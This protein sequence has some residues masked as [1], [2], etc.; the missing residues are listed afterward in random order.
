[1]SA[2]VFLIPPRSQNRLLHSNIVSSALIWIVCD[3]F[4]D[5][6]RRAARFIWILFFVSLNYSGVIPSKPFQFLIDQ[7][8]CMRSVPCI[9]AHVD[10]TVQF[11]LRVN[12]VLSNC[13]CFFFALRISRSPNIS[14]LLANS[15]ECEKKRVTNTGNEQK[16]KATRNK[17]PYL[18]I[19]WC[20]FLR[21]EK[22]VQVLSS[23]KQNKTANTHSKLN[24]LTFDQNVRQLRHLCLYFFWCSEYVFNETQAKNEKI[25]GEKR[26][27]EKKTRSEKKRLVKIQHWYISWKPPK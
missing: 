9:F 10:S 16:K 4:V 8:V 15:Q 19:H 1:M 2:H 3:L 6:S 27:E 5:L 12:S 17:Q 23:R 11:T 7:V 18:L 13:N 20:I 14:P 22:A 25:T 24:S 26:K 21:C